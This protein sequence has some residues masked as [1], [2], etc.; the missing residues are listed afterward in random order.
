MSIDI[1]YNKYFKM[2]EKNAINYIFILF[3]ICSINCVV[4]CNDS[5]AIT[6]K[7]LLFLAP[8]FKIQLNSNYSTL[9][10]VKCDTVGYF[11]CIFAKRTWRSYPSPMSASEIT[12][13]GN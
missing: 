11:E 9:C 13:M 5:Y 2:Q 3:S 12:V 4:E 6:P 8:T 7:C 1:K 10:L